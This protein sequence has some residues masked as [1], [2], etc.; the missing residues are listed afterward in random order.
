MPVKEVRPLMDRLC[1]ELKG[2][3]EAVIT[4]TE[5]QSPPAA[6]PHTRP[7]S[8]AE[9][10][11][12]VLADV[13]DMLNEELR[14][15]RREL[16]E[17]SL[18]V[19]QMRNPKQLEVDQMK[20]QKQLEVDQMK[21]Q[22]QLEV[23]A[24]PQLQQLPIPQELFSCGGKAPATTASTIFGS[25]F[26]KTTPATRTVSGT[27]G[28]LRFG[29]AP[30]AWTG[31]TTTGASAAASTGFSFGPTTA[32]PA[33][34]STPSFS[35][36]PPTAE[37]ATS[38]PAKARGENTTEEGPVSSTP[39]SDAA[40]SNT[41]TSSVVTSA[42]AA[43]AGAATPNS[44]FHFKAAPF[45]IGVEQGKV[46][47]AT[48]KATFEFGVSS[49]AS[50]PFKFSLGG[51]ADKSGSSIFGGAAAADTKT[52]L[53]FGGSSG[54]KTTSNSGGA[55]STETKPVSIFGGMPSSETKTTSIFGTPSV[56]GGKGTDKAVSFFGGATT[57]DKTSKEDQIF[58][59]SGTDSKPASLFGGFG[60]ASGAQ[61]SP[62]GSGS[63]VF[64]GWP[65]FGSAASKP[66]SSESGAAAKPPT[67]ANSSAPKAP[68]PA[69]SGSAPSAPPAAATGSTGAG[70]AATPAP[71]APPA[72]ATGSTGAGAAATPAPSAPPA[73][74]TGST[75]AGAAATP[76]PTNGEGVAKLRH[77][78][79]VQ[80]FT[81]D[82]IGPGETG[83]PANVPESRR[84][85]HGLVVVIEQAG[86]DVIDQLAKE[87]G[88]RVT[89]L[90]MFMPENVQFSSDFQLLY[91]CARAVITGDGSSIA[92][93]K[94]G[95]MHQ[96]RW[97]TAQSRLLRHYMSVT[98]PSAPLVTLVKFIVCVYVPAV[99]GVRHRWDLIDAPRHLTEQL[100]RQRRYLSGGDLEVVQ[101]SLARNSF[102]AHP[103]NVLLA[104]LGDQEETVRAQ[105]VDLIISLRRRR[106]QLPNSLR[107]FCK[108]SINFEA[109]NYLSW[110]VRAKKCGLVIC[111][112]SGD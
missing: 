73:A 2:L 23:Q 71:S 53:I 16:Q 107:R 12:A 100:R 80:R 25:G 13:R 11:D 81:Y 79:T 48:P 39:G 46:V 108:P 101:A 6:G 91:D 3:K 93:R 38:T 42:P 45:V 62:F 59:G 17:L 5:Q 28:G 87:L 56:F 20:N 10:R 21:N 65:S 9:L 50:S 75:G 77:L 30:S 98:S 102:M 34:P 44:S 35:F 84:P 1:D 24:A 63:S 40:V 110:V 72:A 88:Q 19:A 83:E 64:G 90:G 14:Q 32:P 66:A 104:M 7:Q 76:A 85:G 57:T 41:I 55:S 37:G 69:S 52:T 105:A 33:Q 4:L 111:V 94:H 70:A 43:G 106:G 109:N 112:A 8:P 58:G 18:E 27:D 89:L 31:G 61:S 29:Q 51:D 103:E 15:L 97:H 54:N 47:E 67:P 82:V 68:E 95:K 96:A 60:L 78:K 86:D 36:R 92:D 74:A 49:A 22:R 99:V 26:S